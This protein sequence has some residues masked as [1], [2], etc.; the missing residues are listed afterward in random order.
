MCKVD[1]GVIIPSGCS[2]HVSTR[3]GICHCAETAASNLHPGLLYSHDTVN[4]TLGYLDPTSDCLLRVRW[5]NRCITR[6]CIGC[7]RRYKVDRR[8]RLACIF[9]DCS[10]VWCI[11]PVHFQLPGRALPQSCRRLLC[12]C[13]GMNAIIH[14]K[15]RL[16]DT[17]ATLNQ[18]L[19]P[20]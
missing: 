20:S 9:G 5:T 14:C 17:R 1:A 6:F 8:V 11:M 16:H 3:H 13:A 15:P 4:L 2:A 7:M 10:T 19:R 18:H 12:S